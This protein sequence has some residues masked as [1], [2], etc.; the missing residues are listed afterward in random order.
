LITTSFAASV[1]VFFDWSFLR[2]WLSL[3][4]RLKSFSHADIFAFLSLVY[5]CHIFRLLFT[6]S[7]FSH[8]WLPPLSR[9]LLLDVRVS[10]FSLFAF[11][12]SLPSVFAGHCRFS[13]LLV[14]LFAI[15]FHSLLA[16]WPFLHRCSMLQAA[17]AFTLIIAFEGRHD[18]AALSD[19][20]YANTVSFRHFTYAGCR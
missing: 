6:L 11:R 17:I 9:L 18:T 5:H 20:D 16:I 3:M 7:V 19:T 2:C 10:V 13:L 1:F 14:I 8:S 15:D 12:F 4:A